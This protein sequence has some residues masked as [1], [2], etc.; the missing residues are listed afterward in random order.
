M[1][2]VNIGR[3]PVTPLLQSLETPLVGVVVREE[4]IVQ[5][6]MFDRA[7]YTVHFV[8]DT[9]SS[10]DGVCEVLPLAIIL[11]IMQTV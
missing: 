3:M 1:R 2:G 5:C 11:Y 6:H 7:T 9:Q 4:C 8:G 10:T